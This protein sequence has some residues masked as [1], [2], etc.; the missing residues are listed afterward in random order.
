MKEITP[1][2]YFFPLKKKKKKR[3]KELVI[4]EKHHSECTVQGKIESEVSSK[5]SI[6]THNLRK[7]TNLLT[8]FHTKC[9]THKSKRMNCK[10]PREGNHLHR[11]E[12]FR[13][14]RETEK[15]RRE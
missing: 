3:K 6:S 9:K 1:N 2:F 10:N 7:G 8:Q 12:A 4:L 11:A 14:R 13:V 5:P 15:E